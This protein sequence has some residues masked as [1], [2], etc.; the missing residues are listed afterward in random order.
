ML[1]NSEPDPVTRS[2]SG[3]FFWCVSESLGSPGGSTLE[4]T[5]IRPF[6]SAFFCFQVTPMEKKTDSGMKWHSLAALLASGMSLKDSAA[7][8]RIPQRTADRYASLPEF[9]QKVSE[10]RTEIT[11]TIVGKLGSVSVKAVD[12]LQELL[13]PKNEPKTRLDACKLILANLGPLTEQCEL[14]G[15]LDALESGR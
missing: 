4:A 14:R 8:L 12:T 15:R 13:D 11:S 10:I 1:V 2:G 9:K 7:E 5:H 3:S 6:L